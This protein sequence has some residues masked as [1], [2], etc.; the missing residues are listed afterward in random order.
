MYESL[1][2]IIDVISDGS[3]TIQLHFC[4]VRQYDLWFAAG[5]YIGSYHLL[6]TW[7]IE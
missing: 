1:F 7:S 3:G 2:C 4:S 6:R 5:F